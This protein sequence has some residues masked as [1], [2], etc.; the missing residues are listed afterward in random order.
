MSENVKNRPY[1]KHCRVHIWHM[2]LFL[3]LLRWWESIWPMERFATWFLW[4]K[5]WCGSAKE[6]DIFDYRG[7]WPSLP[8][9]IWLNM[10]YLDIMYLKACDG[11]WSSP[12]WRSAV[13]TFWPVL[14]GEGY[15]RRRSSHLETIFCIRLYSRT[16]RYA[17]SNNKTIVIINKF[18][19]DFHDSS[20]K[21]LIKSFMRL[22]HIVP[23]YNIIHSKTK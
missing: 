16:Y 2:A 1:L 22:I 10:L 3:T 4:S 8:L 12:S 9:W 14:V 23:V 7:R 18:F 21:S 19:A 5:W 13:R 17:I 20:M 15:P 11:R 6:V